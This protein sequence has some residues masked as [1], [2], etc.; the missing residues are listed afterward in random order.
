MVT[1][2]PA[3]KDQNGRKYG[4]KSDREWRSIT[5]TSFISQKKKK[6]A[7]KMLQVESHD[8]PKKKSD[9]NEKN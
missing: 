6:I 1:K 3:H 8:S 9:E 4:V 7:N 5:P 2:P